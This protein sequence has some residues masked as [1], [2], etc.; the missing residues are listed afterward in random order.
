[1]PS[2]I[3]T[4]TI[5]CADPNALAA[6]WCEVLGY[7]VSDTD[8]AEDGSFISDPA[9]GGVPLFFQRVPESKT[10]KDRL[11]L[12]LRPPRSMAEEVERVKALGA[13]VFAFVEVEGSFWTVLQDPEGNEFCVLRGPLDGWVPEG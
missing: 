10:V 11:H 4:V 3:D 2:T 8:G 7:V 1:V 9:G 5:D 6:F 13:T 12:D